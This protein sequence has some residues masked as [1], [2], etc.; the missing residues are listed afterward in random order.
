MFLNNTNDDFIYLNQNSIPDELCDT[1]IQLYESDTTYKYKGVTFSG[2]NTNVKDTTDLVIPKNNDTWRKIENFLYEELF[3]NVEKYKKKIN[4]ENL[5][6][7]TNNY[8]IEPR[9]LHQELFTETFQIQKYKK[10]EGKYVYH[11]DFSIKQNSYRVIT[12]LWYLNTVEE[13]GETELWGDFKIK[14]EKGKLFLFP[15][16]WTYPH[17]GKMPIS[18][19][20]YIITGW[21]YISY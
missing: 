5:Y 7:K 19:D 17:T 16:S 2:V 15:A 1:I 14:P 20:K 11:H 10:N 9:I 6:N 8:N 21:L 4:N 12:F 18:H 13:G 3:R